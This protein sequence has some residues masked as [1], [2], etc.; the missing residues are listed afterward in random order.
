VLGLSALAF[1]LVATLLI[2]R[3]FV[4][5]PSS[6]PAAADAVVAMTA[7]QHEVTTAL[8]LVQKQVAP[9]LVLGSEGNQ[10]GELA[11][12][13]CSE[14]QS[15]E[16]VCSAAQGDRLR[17]DARTVGRLADQRGWRKVAMVAPTAEVS[18]ARLLISRCTRAKVLPVASAAAA[19]HRFEQVRDEIG[20]Y[21]RALAFDRSC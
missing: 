16:V 3:L 17:S 2:A 8:Q 19:S 21:L 6:H 7:G 15:F 20:P 11:H 18:R 12:R 13:L 4:S 5:P 10:T 14:P 1:L 9:V